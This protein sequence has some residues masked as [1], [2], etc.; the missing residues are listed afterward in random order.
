MTIG[1]TAVSQCP[2]TPKSDRP[3]DLGFTRRPMVGWFAPFGLIRTGLKALLSELFG[4]YADKREVQAALRKEEPYDYSDRNEIWFDFI[5]DLGDGWDSTYTMA[6]LLAEERLFLEADGV[7]ETPRGQILLLG[8]DEVYPT[9]NRDEYQ[10]RLVGPYRAALPYVPDEK[11]PPHLFAIPGNHD[12]YDG[13]TSFTRL[14]CQER[15]IGGWKTRQAR[16]YFALKLAHGWWIWGIDVQLESDIDQPQL[17]F[18]EA[19]ARDRTQMAPG[20]KIILCTAEP[21]WVYLGLTGTKAYQNFAYFEKSI[22]REYGHRVVIGLAGDIHAYARYQHDPDREQRFVSGG[23]GAFLC[24]THG[25]PES[26]DLPLEDE[27]TIRY[28][29]Y[30]RKNVFPDS[31]TSRWRALGSLLLPL[32]N[33]TF[34]LL[35]GAFYLWYAWVVQSVS[36][37][38]EGGSGGTFLEVIALT[39]PNLRDFIG[40]FR[41]FWKILAHSPGSLVILFLLILSL[42]RFADC[43]TIPRKIA[44]GGAHAA[45]HIVLQFTLMWTFAYFN[46][47]RGWLHLGIN[48]PWQVLL[49]SVEML[50]AGGLLGGMV[51]G[52]YLCLS[53]LGLG[54]HADEIFSCQRIPHYKNFLRFHL[55]GT[56]RLTIY[57]VGVRRV[58]KAWRFMAQAKDGEAWFEPAKGSIADYAKLIERPIEIPL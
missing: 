13:L 54:A 37:V 9:A 4:A 55:E 28:E 57:P 36:V 25:L 39:A 12:W 11:G 35:V 52:L 19:L 16:S 40:A 23:G 6:R 8:G 43:R 29:R 47:N 5:A 27:N 50:I 49:F 34:S 44:V 53:N 51:M 42:M 17:D 22:V 24:P 18:F 3:E 1:V 56:G 2:P 21:S 46:L 10:N 7:R 33:P 48:T 30:E 31:R 32:W 45:L 20:S 26:L 15:W 14:F 58:P 38:R 41:E